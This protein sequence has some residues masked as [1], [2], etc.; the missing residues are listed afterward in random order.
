M[1]EIVVKTEERRKL[2]MSP[3][4]KLISKR[5]KGILQKIQEMQ[6]NFKGEEEITSPNFVQYSIRYP[7]NNPSERNI[8]EINQKSL[9]KAAAAKTKYGLSKNSTATFLDTYSN[10]KLFDN[11]NQF[12]DIQDKTNFD[13]IPEQQKLN[14][15]RNILFNNSKSLI[16]QDKQQLEK[17]SDDQRNDAVDISVI[18]SYISKFKNLIE[19]FIKIVKIINH[20]NK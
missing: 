12:D 9:S 7:N 4:R 1:N 13:L 10:R 2:D 14:I 17:R 8:K 11:T 5:E 3:S 15:D 19:S 16:I 6:E 20:F 18:K